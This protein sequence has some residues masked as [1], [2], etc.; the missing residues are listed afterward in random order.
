MSTIARLLCPL[1]SEL[2]QLEDASRRPAVFLQPGRE[3]GVG[4]DDCAVDS[5]L[6][7]ALQASDDAVGNQR[8]LDH[9]RKEDERDETHSD[10]GQDQHTIA[11]F[12]E[13]LEDRQL[14]H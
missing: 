12:R 13:I 10:P 5:A 4:R 1:R 3:L 8:A 2:Q 9:H 7:E 11:Q 6:V 14:N